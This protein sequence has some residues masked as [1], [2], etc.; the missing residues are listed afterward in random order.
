MKKERLFYLDFVRAVAAVSI[1]ITHFNARYLYLNPPMPFDD[2]WLWYFLYFRRMVSG[3]D[4]SDVPGFPASSESHEC[5]AAPFACSSC[6]YVCG[7]TLAV[8]PRSLPGGGGNHAFYPFPGDCLRYVFCKMQ[9]EGGLEGGA[10]SV[11][12]AGVKWSA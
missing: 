1:V 11:C 8:L 10:G 3:S 5:K 4:Y 2:E 12:C 9:L 6:S 7:G